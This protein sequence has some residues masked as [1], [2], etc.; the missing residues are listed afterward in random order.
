MREKE[1]SN[2]R[3]TNG[4]VD[5]SPTHNPP[6]PPPTPLKSSST[7]TNHH[8][9]HQHLINPDILL[10]R[11]GLEEIE[12]SSSSSHHS[13][14]TPSISPSIKTETVTNNMISSTHSINTHS[15]IK[16]LATLPERMSEESLEDN[17]AFMDITPNALTYTKILHSNTA[18]ES[19]P[20]SSSSLLLEPL[21]EV[22]EEDDC[23]EDR[24]VDENHK[25]EMMINGEQLDSTTELSSSPSAYIAPLHMNV[26]R[27]SDVRLVGSGGNGLS[28]LHSFSSRSSSRSRTPRDVSPAPPSSGSGSDYHNYPSIDPDILLDRLGLVELEPTY[29][30]HHNPT[31]T[32]TSSSSPFIPTSVSN[33]ISSSSSLVTTTPLP[34][35]PERLSEETLDDCHAFTDF[36]VV[37]RPRLGSTSSQGE[38]GTTTPTTS[39]SCGNLVGLL[40]GTL[41]RDNSVSG[42]SILGDAS[43]LETL[44]EFEEDE[45]E[46]EKGEEK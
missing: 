42:G 16:T 11:L 17:H 4:N 30:H 21:Q 33:N 37:M 27:I 26:L 14:H 32:S 5:V 8:H 18:H 41:T 15:T 2:K 34:S 39:G 20:L 12:P 3:N 24:I 43:L 22:M 1:I 7:P 25:K 44:E 40:T 28:T 9:H 23:V 6:P 45:E 13:L 31:D 19:N 38:S 46:E 35:L 10:D 36:K 29:L